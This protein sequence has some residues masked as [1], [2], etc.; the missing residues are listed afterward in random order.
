VLVCGNKTCR[1][2]GALNTMQFF[3]QL[4]PVDCTVKRVGCL[5]RCGNGPNCVLLPSELAV[6]HC[7]TAAHVARLIERQVVH[8][9]GA[10]TI[11]RTLQLK[12]DGNA[13][14][15]M[16]DPSAAEAAYS[17]AINL[18][19]VRGAASTLHILYSNR[20]A[21]RLAQVGRNPLDALADAQASME[22]AP[23]WFRAHSRAG[24]ALLALGRKDEALEAMER[25]LDLQPSLM[26]DAVF[27]AK[28]KDLS[29]SK[30][31]RRAVEVPVPTPAG[32]QTLPGVAVAVPA[33]VES[34][35]SSKSFL[36]AE[37][38]QQKRK[39][40]EW[41]SAASAAAASPSAGVTAAKIHV[42]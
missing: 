29:S 35:P 42:L 15:E 34:S 2:Q 9:E 27:M 39:E 10:E 31:E 13:L 21:A 17:A 22:L 32:Q 1:Q 41:G 19:P 36:T 33:A 24:D 26:G 38:K 40:L 14:M 8:G 23:Q 11:A 28:F 25:T 7:N 18:L 37:E 5:G 12:L 6:G 3:Q 30:R 20:S 4:V 16:G